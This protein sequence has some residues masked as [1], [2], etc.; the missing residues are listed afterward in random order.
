[1]N[2]NCDAPA[3]DNHDRDM[4][5]CCVGC[6][7]CGPD[8]DA[9]LPC[10][11]LPK[12]SST[13]VQLCTVDWCLPYL[14]TPASIFSPRLKLSPRLTGGG[15]PLPLFFPRFSMSVTSLLVWR[16]CFLAAGFLPQPEFP[17]GLLTR[18]CCG[19]KLPRARPLTWLLPVDG[20]EL[21]PVT[22]VLVVVGD[23]FNWE[24]SGVDGLWK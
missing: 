16:T 6:W 17:P 3:I 19:V 22:E 18:S 8:D 10:V 14:S 11:L 9:E 13:I 21:E 24:C 15:K 4:C 7:W 20:P 23:V 5:T 1:M 2:E 12:Q